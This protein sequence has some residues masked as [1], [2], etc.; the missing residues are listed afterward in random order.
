MVLKEALIDGDMLN[1]QIEFPNTAVRAK[2]NR[3]VNA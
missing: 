1:Q 3:N 2:L